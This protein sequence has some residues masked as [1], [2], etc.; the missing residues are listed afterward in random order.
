MVSD[1]P[2]IRIKHSLNTIKEL[3]LYI[4]GI[5]PAVHQTLLCG[6]RHMC[7]LYVWFEIHNILGV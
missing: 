2:Q 4:R 7:K 3:F 5:Q 6:P 1:G